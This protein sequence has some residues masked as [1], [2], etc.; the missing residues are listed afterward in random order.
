[1]KT[2]VAITQ[3]KINSLQ[4][5]VTGT[6]GP[7]GYGKTTLISA[8]THFLVL[9]LQ[10]K[11]ED[12][13]S[14]FRKLNWNI[15][16]NWLDLNI[17]KSMVEG[18][19]TFEITDIIKYRYG[20]AF[21]NKHDLGVERK[22]AMDM[23]DSYISAYIHSIKGIT[24][25][26]NSEF[27]CKLTGKLSKCYS[28]DMVY[29]KERWEQA[30][31]VIDDYTIIIDDD[32]NM[33]SF[34]NSLN[35]Q[36]FAKADTG[37]PLF[38]RLIRQMYQGTVYLLS[39]SQSIKRI[40]LE[41]RELIPCQ[42][43]NQKHCYVCC[44]FWRTQRI[45]ERF[46]IKPLTKLEFIYLWLKYGKNN[47]EK[48]LLKPNRFKKL[49]YKFTIYQY[50]LYSKGFVVYPTILDYGS[51]LVE[52]EEFDF[53]VPVQFAFGAL[54]SENFRYFQEI[55]TKNSTKRIEDVLDNDG[56]SEVHNQIFLKIIKRNST[57]AR[58]VS[59]F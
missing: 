55:M 54:N 18:Y 16:Y 42:I 7:V 25:L 34:T 31:W 56:S 24:I 20:Y 46:V 8:L 35:F 11:M 22:Y 33:D 9:K 49:M 45:I 37:S 5:Y 47:V 52:N 50:K 29:M 3:D 28:S 44:D 40:V 43:K 36:K 10:K 12:I 13:I 17:K 41:E 1:M 53:V 58:M 21:I 19:N 39:S 27:R 15:D 30:D 59:G 48:A 51:D 57:E 2:P 38:R 26:S 4:C 6:D 32:S 14:E 23:L